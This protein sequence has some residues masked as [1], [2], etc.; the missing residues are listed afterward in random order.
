MSQHLAVLRRA[1]IV[2]ERREGKWIYYS[3]IAETLEE[4]NLSWGNFTEQAMDSVPEMKPI[5]KRLNAVN[6]SQVKQQCAVATEKNEFKKNKAKKGV[7]N[8]D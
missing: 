1:E 5:L 7:T 4:F 2:K 3:L 8:G 6:L